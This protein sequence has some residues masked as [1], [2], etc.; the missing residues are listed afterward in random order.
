[1]K[2]TRMERHQCVRCQRWIPAWWFSAGDDL[3]WWH[4]HCIII[5]TWFKRRVR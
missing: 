3:G 4:W 2:V 5:D 1:M